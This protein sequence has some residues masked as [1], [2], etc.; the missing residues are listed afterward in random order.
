MTLP[1]I[2]YQQYKDHLYRSERVR[3][4]KSILVVPH[5]L[6]S[7]DWIY[8]H[9]KL[10]IA[11]CDSSNF[12]TKKGHSPLFHNDLV[13]LAKFYG[14]QYRRPL[15]N[16]KQTPIAYSSFSMASITLSIKINNATWVDD[17]FLNP[18]WL[19][20]KILTLLYII[21]SKIFDKTRNTETS[22]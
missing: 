4:L 13:Y 3:D 18:Y 6:S 22:L 7:V 12:W 16:K 11:I 5:N 20:C 15:K 19:S 17:F 9:C 10:H 2:M 1:V 8:S 21:F 14:Q